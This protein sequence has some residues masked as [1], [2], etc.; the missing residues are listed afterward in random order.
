MYQIPRWIH[1]TIFVL[2]LRLGPSGGPVGHMFFFHVFLLHN[3]LR[4]CT[5]SRI[6]IRIVNLISIIRIRKI[7]IRI[8]TMII[9]RTMITI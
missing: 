3:M 5:I 8:R 9:I 6:I 2:G 1:N 7:T 4:K